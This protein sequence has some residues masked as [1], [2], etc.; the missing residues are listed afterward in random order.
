MCWSPLGSAMLA[1]LSAGLATGGRIVAWRQ[2]VWSNGFMGRPTQG[3]DPRLLALTHVSSRYAGSE[4]RDEARAIFSRAEAPRDFDTI[5][6]PFPERGGATL[7]RWSDR[8]ARER[9]GG[10][11]G[12]EAA[13]EQEDADERSEPVA[14]P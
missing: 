1:R 3:G 8:Q 7:L 2:D 12:G 14:A 5:E 10:G 4:I 11:A 6:V 9:A 13:D